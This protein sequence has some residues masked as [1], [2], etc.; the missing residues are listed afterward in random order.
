[1]CNILIIVP[2]YSI[3]IMCHRS[4]L[5]CLGNHAYINQYLCLKLFFTRLV[6]CLSLFIV[7]GLVL[8]SYYFRQL[9]AA[10]YPLNIHKQKHAV[11][12]CCQVKSLC[13]LRARLKPV[14]SFFFIYTGGSYHVDIQVKCSM[15]WS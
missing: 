14:N 15:F 1:M 5:I 4:V 8:R 9:T 12:K 13:S 7:K 2:V 10:N 11:H 3:L 6:V